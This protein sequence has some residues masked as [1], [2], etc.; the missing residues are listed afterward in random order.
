M[1]ISGAVRVL[2]RNTNNAIGVYIEKEIYFK[3]LAY[4]I[5]GAGKSEICKAGQQV[6]E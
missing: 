4:A 5:T 6:R 3:E 1:W 2:Q